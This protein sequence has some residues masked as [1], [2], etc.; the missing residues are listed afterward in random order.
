VY[1]MLAAQTRESL[2][3]DDENYW[4]YSK[5]YVDG[6]K[7]NLIVAYDA[8]ESAAGT[9]LSAAPTLY[10]V[11][12]TIDEDY[13]TEVEKQNIDKYQVETVG[14]DAFWIDRELTGDLAGKEY[15]NKFDTNDETVFVVV[16]LD[17][18]LDY[19][20]Y[21]GNLNDMKE[22]DDYNPVEVQI[23]KEDD[24]T[25]ELVYI[26]KTEK[27]APVT[28]SDKTEV[29]SVEVWPQYKNVIIDLYVEDGSAAENLTVAEIAAELEAEGYENIIHDAN[30]DK[31]AFTKGV[32]VYADMTVHQ[33]QVYKVSLTKSTGD[34]GLGPW[35]LSGSEFFLEKDQA[36][37]VTLAGTTGNWDGADVETA[38]TNVTLAKVT[39][40]ADKHSVTI[41]VK[42]TAA[43]DQAVALKGDWEA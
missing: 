25:A 10:K 6:E 38:N 1:F 14:V 2:K 32:S 15:L 30:T 23:V 16:E 8:D 22:D 19:K 36:V 39:V 41:T 33:K 3:Y 42:L 34:A 43:A 24:Q 5:A 35:T 4:D 29:I 37:A 20:I 17:K 7:T 11:K 26:Y 18:D 31:W 27:T 40:S 21:E 28:K 9:V 12:K 13:I